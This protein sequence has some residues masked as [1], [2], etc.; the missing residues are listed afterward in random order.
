MNDFLFLFLI[1]WNFLHMSSSW[2]LS[3]DNVETL[4]YDSVEIFV[5]VEGGEIL[6]CISSNIL[7]TETYTWL[8]QY[9][10]CTNKLL[11]YILNVEKISINY[12]IEQVN[13][14]EVSESILLGVDSLGSWVAHENKAF[15]ATYFSHFIYWEF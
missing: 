14:A 6:L 2:K 7:V 13:I 5:C 10:I 12:K 9:L 8:T 1:K 11:F 15:P 4:Y 3:Y